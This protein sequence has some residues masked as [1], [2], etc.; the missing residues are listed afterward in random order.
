[1]QHSEQI[2]VGLLAFMKGQ[3]FATICTDGKEI[4]TYTQG[5]CTANQSLWWAVENLTADGFRFAWDKMKP[6]AEDA[7]KVIAKPLG[8]EISKP[9]VNWYGK[10]NGKARVAAETKWECQLQCI[11]ESLKY[12]S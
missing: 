5:N 9:G 7:F 2:T 3:E 4:R 10:L 6:Y 12:H 1:M 11:R 8:W